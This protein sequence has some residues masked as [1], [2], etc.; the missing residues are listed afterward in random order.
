[1][2]TTITEREQRHVGEAGWLR[3][4]ATEA[5]EPGWGEAV[6]LGGRQVA[7]FRTAEGEVYA[8]AH[9]D[10]RTGAYVMARGIVGSRGGRPTI[11][12]PLLK[13][14]YD[15]ETGECLGNPDLYLRTYRARVVAGEVEV[16]LAA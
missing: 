5:L 6:L 14:V 16:E 1:M 9:R 4:C 7:L 2:T 8:A 13:E 12:S 11:A 10:P 15:L 3:A